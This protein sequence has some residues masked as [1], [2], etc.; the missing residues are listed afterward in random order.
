M[1]FIPALPPIWNKNID[2]GWVEFKNG[3]TDLRGYLAKPKGAKKRPAIVMVHENLGVI[4]HRQDVTRRL[5]DNGYVALTV[6]LYSRIGGRSPQDF[7]TPQE[8]RQKA[9][10]AAPD[11]QAVGDLEAACRYLEGLDAVDPKCIGAIGYCM[12]GGTLHAWICGRSTNVKAA[13]VYYGT[14]TVPAEW[15]P[16]GKAINRIDDADKLQCPVQ[17][18]H[19]DVDEAVAPQS[20]KALAEAY[21]RT[22]KPVELFSYPG[23]NHA[24]DDDTH[25]NYHAEASKQSWKRSLEFLARYLGR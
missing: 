4:E 22:G 18:H 23:A 24:Y 13:V 3:G 7:K 17:I 10:L 15:R 5:A 1:A 2:C 21:K 6:D 20:V 16:D 14:T 12:G 19:G 11:E 8:R 9:F 25:P